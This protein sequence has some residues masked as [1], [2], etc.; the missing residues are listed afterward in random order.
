MKGR[1]NVLDDRIKIQND[2]DKAEHWD[3]SHKIKL[4]DMLWIKK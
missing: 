3:K 4:T 2:L 1:V